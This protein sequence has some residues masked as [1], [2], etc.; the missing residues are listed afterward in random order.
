M[1]P[2][3][4]YDYGLTETIRGLVNDMEMTHDFRILFKENI[5]ESR[6]DEMI[7]LNIYRVVQESINNITTPNCANTCENVRESA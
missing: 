6:F 7:E 4:I 3:A 1:V 5:K 2:N